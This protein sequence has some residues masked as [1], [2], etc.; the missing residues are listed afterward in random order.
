M[1]EIRLQTGN[2]VE[3]EASE[4]DDDEY[5]VKTDRESTRLTPQLQPTTTGE[6]IQ[7]SSDQLTDQSRLSDHQTRDTDQPTHSR[8]EQTGGVLVSGEA[9]ESDD[10]YQSDPIQL[11][12]PLKVEDNSGLASFSPVKKSPPVNQTVTSNRHDGLLH[13][14]LRETNERLKSHA[15]SF[16][17]KRIENAV[18]DLK[19]ILTQL[20]KSQAILKD[21][22]ATLRVTSNDLFNLEDKFD[23]VTSCTLIPYINIAPL[24]SQKT[25]RHFSGSNPVITG[26]T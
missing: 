12:I 26:T 25:A 23:I 11:N 21:V 16:R 5:E 10:D 20:C 6:T 17:V 7:S 9:S 2:V 14:K 24:P 18:K 4:S 13:R 1:S 8:Q 19:I 3:G 15:E 22:S